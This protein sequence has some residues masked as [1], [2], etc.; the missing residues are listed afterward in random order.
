MKWSTQGHLA[1]QEQIQNQKPGYLPIFSPKLVDSN[2]CSEMEGAGGIAENMSIWW[3]K[4]L[5]LE[6][7]N[8]LIQRHIANTAGSQKL[9]VEWKNK[10]SS[11][12][13]IG[14]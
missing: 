1:S 10:W 11:T 5:K 8:W 3:M 9:I 12:E 13:A 7:V 14:R 4:Q 6:K 2:T